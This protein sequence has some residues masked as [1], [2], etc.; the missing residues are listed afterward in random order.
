MSFEYTPSMLQIRE[1]DYYRNLLKY[2][3]SGQQDEREF[4]TT[5]IN[6]IATKIENLKKITLSTL[7]ADLEKEHPYEMYKKETKLNDYIEGINWRA[8][9]RYNDNEKAIKKL[10]YDIEFYNIKLSRLPKP[11][12]KEAANLLNGKQLNLS[13]RFTIA[14][15]VLNI[16]SVLRTLNIAELQ[17]YELLAFI[18]GCNKDNARDLMNGNYNSKDRDL[19]EYIQSLKLK[20]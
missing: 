16:E 7:T 19:K 10:E 6:N 18:M 13:E 17:K 15:E 5:Q 8:E 2:I 12:R 14:K 9:A 3:R 4:I 11:T 20:K 1:D